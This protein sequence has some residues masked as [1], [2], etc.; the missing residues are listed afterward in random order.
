MNIWGG[1]LKQNAYLKKKKKMY[2][3]DVLTTLN[4]LEITEY[5][6]QIFCQFLIT[7]L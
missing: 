2:I 3:Y 6:W 1:S 7:S 4:L 5:I